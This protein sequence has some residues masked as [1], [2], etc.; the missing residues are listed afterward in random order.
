[1]GGPAV[2]DEIAK[3]VAKNGHNAL[4]IAFTD[5]LGSLKDER[6]TLLL[7]ELVRDKEFFWRPT[8]MRALADLADR[9]ARDDFRAALG[10]RLSGCRAAAIVALEKLDDRESSARIKDLL[11]DDIYDVRAQAA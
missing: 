4:S 5:A 3:F 11:G 7:R 8:A 1:R 2:A 10:D 6:I 9:S